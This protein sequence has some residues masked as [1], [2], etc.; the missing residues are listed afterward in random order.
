MKG[1]NQVLPN[2]LLITTNTHNFKPIKLLRRFLIAT[3]SLGIMP[4]G[5]HTI[6]INN[7]LWGLLFKT[8]HMSERA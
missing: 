4:L 2:A 6:I 7:G 3:E 8:S 1:E 5:K